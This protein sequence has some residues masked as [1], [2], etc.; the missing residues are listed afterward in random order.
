MQ[1][2]KRTDGGVLKFNTYFIN[3]KEGA[4]HCFNTKLY[5]MAKNDSKYFLF[6]DAP[7]LGRY[8]LEAHL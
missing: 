4:S 3:A 1:K 8:Q 2:H 6:M 5:K 7:L